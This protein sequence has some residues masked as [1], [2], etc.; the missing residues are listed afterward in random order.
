MALAG[1]ASVWVAACVVMLVPL[2]LLLL[3]LLLPM[4]TRL[5]LPPP[6]CT[7]SKNHNRWP[8]PPLS[9]RPYDVTFIG[10]LEYEAK[11]EVSGVTLH[12]CGLKA[13]SVLCMQQLVVL[14]WV[15][16]SRIGTG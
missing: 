7:R 4:L 14:V 2:L 12:R 11:A 3:C 10:K 1:D 9:E 16:A 5:L 15:G 6:T 8:I 13:S